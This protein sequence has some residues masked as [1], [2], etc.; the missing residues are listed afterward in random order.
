MAAC[1]E[2]LHP[3]RSLVLIVLI[4]QGEQ[5][6]SP[7]VVGFWFWF[8]RF[9]QALFLIGCVSR[10]LIIPDYKISFYNFHSYY[11]ISN[12]PLDFCDVSS[13]VFFFISDFIRNFSLLIFVS[14]RV[15]QFCIFK[16]QLLTFI[17]LCCLFLVLFV[18]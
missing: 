16:N 13:N 14:F 2:N 3:L 7:V 4:A 11:D 18:L 8:A 12:E 6:L 17:I 5:A 10:S 15:C 9:L 1:R